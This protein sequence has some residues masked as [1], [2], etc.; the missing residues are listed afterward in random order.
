MASSDEHFRL[1]GSLYDGVL[2][3]AL[4]AE[5]GAADLQ[6]VASRSID[7]SSS[8]MQ[9][10]LIIPSVDARTGVS[11]LRMQPWQ[12]LLHALK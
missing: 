7:L 2:L 5:G 4:Q 3:E 6:D 11:R 10:Q 1:D 9:Y 12:S 8:L